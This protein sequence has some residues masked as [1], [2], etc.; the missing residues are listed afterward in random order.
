MRSDDRK[1][2]LLVGDHRTEY[3]LRPDRAHR[4]PAR[5]EVTIHRFGY[6]RPPSLAEVP[7]QATAPDW[8]VLEHVEWSGLPVGV[9]DA[10]GLTVAV[11]SDWQRTVSYLPQLAATVDLLLLDTAGCAW[12][13]A[14]GVDNAHAFNLEGRCAEEPAARE[15]DIDVLH[16]GHD[17]PFHCRKWRL[18][19]RLADLPARYTVRLLTREALGRDPAGL[20]IDA[21]MEWLARAR[22]VVNH[23]YRGELNGR[24]V[25]AGLAGA[26]LM[27]EAG[28]LEVERAFEDGVSYRSYTPATLVSRV[29]ALLDDPE[30]AAAIAEA[31]RDA[32]R[33][34]ANPAPFLRLVER[35]EGSGL[36][37]LAGTRRIQ[38]LPRA[39]AVRTLA[40]VHLGSIATRPAS[41]KVLEALVPHLES[42]LEASWVSALVEVAKAYQSGDDAFRRARLQA[43]LEHQDAALAHAPS[44][45]VLLYNRADALAALG[46]AGARAALE[47]ALAATAQA[48]ARFFWPGCQLL[49]DQREQEALWLIDRLF[50]RGSPQR[51]ADPR[52]LARYLAAALER[53]LAALDQQAGDLEGCRGRLTRAIRTGPRRPAH[54]VWLATVCGE[55]GRVDEALRWAELAARVHP[56]DPAG[57]RCWARVAGSAGRADAR[58]ALAATLERQ[59]RLF[60]HLERVR[61]ELAR[62]E[63]AA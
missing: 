5:Y 53:R 36:E 10:P 37:R 34:L 50:T 13:R 52:W 58:R 17:S 16:A 62:P 3:R 51:A 49:V 54:L 29:R 43:A 9:E 38:A 47:V 56:T 23:A 63:P 26:V 39:E 41:L 19:A 6:R 40:R 22:V 27:C 12:A 15:R 45:P 33:A 2:I 46:D 20:S 57:Y 24:C 32:A 21:Y 61:D 59:A 42:P 44:D 60:P 30:R 4:V 55:L 1:H 25:E 48:P 18:L 31:G 8:T 14:A 28:N 35:I 11:V 7:T